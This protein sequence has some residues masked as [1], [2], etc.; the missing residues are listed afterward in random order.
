[1]L[2][3]VDEVPAQGFTFLGQNTPSLHHLYGRN[4]VM[5]NLYNSATSCRAAGLALLDMPLWTIDGGLV[6][7]V[8]WLF[9][10]TRRIATRRFM[11]LT[12]SSVVL[13]VVF[14]NLLSSALALAKHFTN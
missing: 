5:R 7:S 12:S 9:S 1:M 4:G 14:Q 8:S 13:N 2:F 3:K 6:L 11:P 10:I